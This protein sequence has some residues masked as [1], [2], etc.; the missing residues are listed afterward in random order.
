MNKLLF[1]A[2]ILS[3]NVATAADWHVVNSKAWHWTGHRNASDGSEDEYS[4]V[5]ISVDRDSVVREGEIRRVWWKETASKNGRVLD[6]ISLITIDCAHHTMRTDKSGT[7]YS[8]SHP[9]QWQSVRSDLIFDIEPDDPW[10]HVF[11]A[12]CLDR[13][14]LTH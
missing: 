13:W 2:L 6:L 10:D 5:S 12:V 14:S 11:A 3:I 8:F 7:R 1:I 9:Y 4:T